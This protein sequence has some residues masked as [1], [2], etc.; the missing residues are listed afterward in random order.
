MNVLVSDHE[1]LSRQLEQLANA[2]NTGR[3]VL[4]SKLADALCGTKSPRK[5]SF[6]RY[7]AWARRRGYRRARML[8]QSAVAEMI[9]RMAEMDNE[10]DELARASDALLLAMVEH[11]NAQEEFVFPMLRSSLRADLLGAL[12]RRYRKIRSVRRTEGESL[13]H[14]ELLSGSSLLSSS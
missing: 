14:A 5:W 12:A 6:A 13:R 9:S 1:D 2:D 3:P 4:S 11:L 10:N 8:K 7:C